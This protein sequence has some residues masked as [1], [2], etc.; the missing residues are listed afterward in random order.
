MTNIGRM[1]RACIVH[2]YDAERRCTVCGRW[3]LKTPQ[4]YASDFWRKVNKNGP[5]GCWLW[6]GARQP[7]GYG[8]IHPQGRPD[9]IDYAH[10]YAFR[11]TGKT[12]PKGW[13]VCHRCDNPP[14]VNPE[15]LFAA[16]Q[17]ENLADCVRKGRKFGARLHP[18]QVVV[19]RERFRAGESMTDLANDYG[20][21][22]HTVYMAVSGRTYKAIS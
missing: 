13:S 16:P 21:P 11:S 3:A 22:R 15:H 6:M 7:R 19:I 12:I 2:K 20:V 4:R 9:I 18:R 8:Q 17:K 10:R 14:C 5:N 1:E